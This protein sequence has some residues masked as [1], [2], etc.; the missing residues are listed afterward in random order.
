VALEGSWE[1]GPLE[2]PNKKIFKKKG[3]LLQGGFLK[4]NSSKLRTHAIGFFLTKYFSFDQITTVLN[5]Q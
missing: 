5:V 4:K 2:L 1:Q 3:K